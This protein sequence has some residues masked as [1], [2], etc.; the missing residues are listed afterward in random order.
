[1]FN[2]ITRRILDKQNMSNDVDLDSL[3]EEP[4]PKD[5]KTVPKND[6]IKLIRADLQAALKVITSLQDK[7]EVLE[8]AKKKHIIRAMFYMSV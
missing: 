8:N 5:T 6:S 3:T 2:E 7:I 1:M 4:G